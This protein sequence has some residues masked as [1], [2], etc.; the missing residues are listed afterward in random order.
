M[1][2]FFT[3]TMGYFELAVEEYIF[4]LKVFSENF[5]RGYFYVKSCIKKRGHREI[6]TSC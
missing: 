4:H 1:Y 5:K 3:K 6:N 2:I